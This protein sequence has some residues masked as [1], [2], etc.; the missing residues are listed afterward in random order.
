MQPSIAIHSKGKIRFRN[1]QNDNFA[2]QQTEC[3]LLI[4]PIQSGFLLSNVTRTIDYSH[5]RIVLLF[6]LRE[7]PLKKTYRDYFES[8]CR[9]Q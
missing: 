5:P 1:L 9:N 7:N 6:V 2:E 3:H 4:T 8:L